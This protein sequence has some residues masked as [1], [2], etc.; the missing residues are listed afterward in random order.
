MSR[1]D[2]TRRAVALVMSGQSMLGD[3]P[4]ELPDFVLAADRLVE[5]ADIPGVL[6][7]VVTVAAVLACAL[8]ERGGDA[9]YLLARLVDTVERS[10]GDDPFPGLAL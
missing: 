2:N 5:D 1:G 6:P 4:D 9:A 10:A 8:E 7:A 3:G